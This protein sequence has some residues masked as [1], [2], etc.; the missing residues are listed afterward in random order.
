[1]KRLVLFVLT[2]G[3]LV[4]PISATDTPDSGKI[5]NELS[6]Y[7]SAEGKKAFSKEADA[8]YAQYVTENCIPAYNEE[9]VLEL[10]ERASFASGSELQAINEELERYGVYLY[11]EE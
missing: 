6:V 2:L 11:S 5:G 7:S 3:I 4:T 8:E 9:M 10:L 1:M